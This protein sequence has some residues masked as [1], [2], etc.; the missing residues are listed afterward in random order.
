M[1]SSAPTAP[2]PMVSVDR[3]RGMF[4]AVCGAVLGVAIV[5]T[6]DFALAQLTHVDFLRSPAKEFA[7]RSALLAPAGDGEG[8]VEASRQA[9]DAYRRLAHG[10]P[11][12][13]DPDLAASLH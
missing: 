9:V 3:R 7:Q 13:Y 4:K 2:N 12:H 1:T 8:A 5:A 6:A 10:R 11:A